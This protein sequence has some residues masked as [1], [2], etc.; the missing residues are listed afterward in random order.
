MDNANI[1]KSTTP[2]VK[3]AAGVFF[4]CVAASL[5]LQI[6]LAIALMIWKGADGVDLLSSS[7]V[8]TVGTSVML[9]GAMLLVLYLWTN[10]RKINPLPA[11]RAVPLKPLGWG[12]AAV[13]GL[14]ALFGFMYIAAAADYLFALIGYDAGMPDG[15]SF[16]TAGKMIA[17]I[18]CVALLPAVVEEAVFRGIVLRGLS[19]MGKIPAILLSAAAFC[20][21]HMNPAQTV[22]QF[23]LGI[24]LAAAAV[25]TGSL[26]APM[27]MHFLNN[28]IVIV[29][30]FAG[31][32]MSF[33]LADKHFFW[34]APVMLIAGAGIIIGASASYRKFS[35]KGGYA[36]PPELFPPREKFGALMLEENNTIL[37]GLGAF[38]I[39]TVVWITMLAIG[40]I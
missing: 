12:Y 22:H 24:A 18:V 11:I 27:I 32:D 19:R 23:L 29:L 21:T 17:G 16:D 10:A 39:T 33:G 5:G 25:E 15:F 14:A 36:P 34:L 4:F 1:E 26:T 20:L 7:F 6:A 37:F 2:R 31:A 38:I 3:D 8:F 28:A 13:T 35:K 40:L 9:Q 30:D